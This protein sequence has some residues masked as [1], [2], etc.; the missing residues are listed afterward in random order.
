MKPCA[1]LAFLV[2]FAGNLSATVWVDDFS[3][4]TLGATNFSAPTSSGNLAL[5]AN[6]AQSRVEVTSTG[7]LAGAS[8]QV[9]WEHQQTIAYNSAWS[10]AAE[11]FSGDAALF[12]PFGSGDII[13]LS[14]NVVSSVDASD[15]AQFNFVV[16]DPFG[17]VIHGAR[18]AKRTDDV[19]LDEVIH[20]GLGTGPLTGSITLQFNPNTHLIA[21][22]YD[23]G[24]GSTLLGTTDIS[25]WSMT[26]GSFSFYIEAAASNITP[27]DDEILG[28][29]SI[30]AGLLYMDT[31]ILATPEP[32]RT[33][34]LI[35]GMG[36]TMLRRR[37]KA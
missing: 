36:C 25:D 16:G 29:V 12:G 21:A 7:G 27:P 1:I 11:V 32:G 33:V 13:D 18:F 4:T 20:G 35:A 24:S 26:S 31:V 3:G 23:F 17:S 2:A 6:S 9:R 10:F 15:R 28:G 22:L 34:L 19:D 37:R 30:P 5:Q 14:L 8:H